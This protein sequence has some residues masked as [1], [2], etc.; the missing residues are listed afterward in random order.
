MVG[1]EAGKGRVVRDCGGEGTRMRR[2]RGK[3]R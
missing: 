2:G 3:K 1:D